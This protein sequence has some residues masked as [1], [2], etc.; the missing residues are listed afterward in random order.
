MKKKLPFFFMAALA[1]TCSIAQTI[2][3]SMKANPSLNSINVET[4]R[5]VSDYWRFQPN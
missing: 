2:D 4:I 3:W 1:A 5:D